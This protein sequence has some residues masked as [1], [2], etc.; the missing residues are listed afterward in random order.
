MKYNVRFNA[1]GHYKTWTAATRSELDQLID[2][3]HAHGWELGY[4][5]M[6]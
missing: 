3:I 1:D 6:A 5:W 4:I 2:T